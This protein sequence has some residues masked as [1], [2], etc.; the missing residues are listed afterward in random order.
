MGVDRGHSAEA[1]GLHPI[2]ARRGGPDREGVPAAAGLRW[3]AV[4]VL[5]PE[6]QARILRAAER[7]FYRSGYEGVPMRRIA[8]EV[9]I[10]VSALYKY[11]ANKRRRSSPPSRIRSCARWF[12]P[13][14]TSST[15]SS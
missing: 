11:F 7:Q 10:S 1:A 8:A 9:R 5:K 15:A 2:A 12:G 6:I 14:F 3:P 4:Q 13:S